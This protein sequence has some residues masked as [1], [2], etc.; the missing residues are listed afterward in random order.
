MSVALNIAMVAIWV[1]GV[2]GWLWYV[3]PTFQS[4]QRYII[5]GVGAVLAVRIDSVG[6]PIGA[7]VL[8]GWTGVTYMSR[9]RGRHP[10]R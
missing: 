10:A 5:A 7:I 4:P 1:I 2:V 8:L 9:R 6:L 3:G